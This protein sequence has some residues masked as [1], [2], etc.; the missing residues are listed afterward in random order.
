MFVIESKK[1]KP[2]EDIV[3]AQSPAHQLI[4]GCSANGDDDTVRETI[5]AGADDFIVKPFKLDTF[6]K[7]LLK[8]GLL[9][10]IDDE[11]V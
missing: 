9:V 10:P 2:S 8:I 7:T 3:P 6:Q 1:V 5:A 11:L 4:I